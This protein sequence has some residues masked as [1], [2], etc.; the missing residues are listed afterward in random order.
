MNVIKQRTKSD[1][2]PGTSPTQYFH[3]NAIPLLV[4]MVVAMMLSSCDLLGSDEETSLRAGRV[5]VANGGNFSEQNGRI[6]SF[7]PLSGVVEQSRVMSSLLQSIVER[8]GVVDALLTT[9]L[10]GRVDSEDS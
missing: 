4:L 9:F 5:L 7:D 2:C 1:R 8:E 10:I 6:T 3:R